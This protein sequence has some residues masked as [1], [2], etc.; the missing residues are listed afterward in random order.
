MSNSVDKINVFLRH[1][2]AGD[3]PMADLLRLKA[4]AFEAS[5]ADAR[6]WGDV[7]HAEALE[8]A[9]RHARDAIA[10]EVASRAGYTD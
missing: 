3:L 8:S 4:E 1:L 10:S 7:A 2:N 9:A 5:A 6:G